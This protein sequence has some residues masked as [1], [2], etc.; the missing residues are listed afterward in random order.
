[1]R[2]RRHIFRLQF[3]TSVLAWFALTGAA[4]LL[5]Q[6]A[7]A[8][9]AAQ[10]AAPRQFPIGGVRRSEDLP[11]SALRRSIENLP[12]AARD[13]A[14]RWL[15]S[16]HFTEGDLPALRADGDGGIF[17]VC[18]PAPS[19]L[20]ADAGVSE[21]PV[22]A[23]AALPVSPFPAS[24]IF[25]SRP[26]ATNVLFINFSGE[27]VTGTDWNTTVGRTSIPAVAFSQDSDLTTFSD[28]E[29]LSIRRIWQRMAEDYAPFNIDVTTE[30]PASFTT[31]TAMALITRQTD[32]LGNLNPYNTSGGV[33]YVNVFATSTY[34]KA[35]PAWIYCD[36]LANVES[37]IA[38][39]ASHEIGHNMGLSHDG[40]TDG[41]EYYGGHGSGDTSWGPIM[42]TGYNRNVSQWSKGE[43]YLAN[44]TQDDLAT[45]AGK[46]SYRADD[47]GNTLATATALVLTDTTNVVSTT[48]ET[49]LTNQHPANKG[50]LERTTDVDVFSFVTGA[51]PVKFTVNPWISPSGTRGGNPDLLLSLFNSAGVLLLTNNP[52]AQTLA[53]IQTNLNEGIYYL[54]IANAGVGTPLASSPSGYSAY[55]S[56][57]QYFIN[58]SISPASNFI[59]PPVAEIAL[60][61]LSQAGQSN[62]T[63]S[64]TYADD[65]SVDVS[66]IDNNDIRVTG[67][68]GYDRLAQLV[69]LN[70]AANGT[71]RTA[72]YRIAPS[73]GGTWASADNGSYAF[74][75]RDGQVL[76]TQGAAVTG[77]LL[78]VGAI[79]VPTVIYSANMD[80]NPGWTLDSQWQYGT[81]A[82][83]STGPTG[84]YTGTKVI[85]Y[86]LTGNYANNL[87]TKY[88]TTPSID[89]TGKSSLILHFK[90]WLRSKR[91]DTMGIQVS[92]NGTTWTSVWNTTNPVSDTSW[93]DVQYSL[94]TSVSGCPTLRLRWSLASNSS[95]SD[96]GWNLDDVELLGDGTVD[97][98]PPMPLLS[99]ADLTVSG[100]P[101]HACSVTY[102]DSTAVRLVSLDATDLLVTGPHG[103]SNLVEFVGADMPSDG[104]PITAIYSIPAPGGAWT[105]EANGT[106]TITLQ[107]GAVEDSLGNIIPETVLGTFRVN[108]PTASPGVLELLQQSDFIVTGLVGGP[109]VPAA[110]NYVL[111]NSGGSTLNWTAGK[112]QDWLA[113][114]LMEGS[115]EAGAQQSVEVSINTEASHL[116]TGSYSDV[117]TFLNATTG[118][119]SH[120]RRVELTVQPLPLRLSFGSPTPENLELVL[121][122]QASLAYVLDTSMDLSQWATVVTNIAGADGLVRFTIPT[123]TQPGAG[124]FRARALP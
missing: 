55:G 101:S 120:S 49:D 93:Q 32:A 36:N 42:G 7:P 121:Q 94:P 67:P 97:A 64:V 15:G 92:T 111:T 112:S 44:N 54:Q 59:V 26:G 61:N 87:T 62:W 51:G 123:P 11:D 88:A 18:P 69:S 14:T 79:S 63:F 66:S 10:R 21:P 28:Q 19:D 118:A 39:A 74:S 108:I 106:Y 48:P 73:S 68:G 77:R 103:Y 115:L 114:S 83:G 70:S 117:I 90:R 9:A 1:M 53:Q 72:T 100:S 113:L 56:I 20:P 104:S 107:D 102:T 40:K 50:V 82:E 34:A 38:E 46:I 75:V 12:P 23:A 24:L 57:G 2:A 35:R 3:K 13:R 98:D 110:L 84:G 5:A 105:A 96:L 124:F 116:P 30:R 95:Q 41:T 109:F 8:P 58:G 78:G 71:P 17:F 27:T 22:V 99:V 80:S 45:I 91:S 47:H 76:D 29:Q 16:F 81:P 60:T 33:A 37:Y 86:N 52:S 43:Y 85:A 6:N 89:C 122:G 25:H 119:E 31:R 65:V 4:S